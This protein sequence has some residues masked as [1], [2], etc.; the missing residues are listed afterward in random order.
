MELWPHGIVPYVI[1]DEHFDELQIEFIEAIIREINTVSCVKFVVRTTEVNYIQIRFNSLTC[2]SEVGCKGKGR[3]YVFLNN[4]CM[5]RNDI[6][7]E[8]MHVLGFFHEHSRPDRDK[9]IEI[10]WE[11]IFDDNKKNFK[12]VNFYKPNYYHKIY[13]NTTY[14]FTS[15]MHYESRAWSKN[16]KETMIP[17][18]KSVKIKANGLSELDVLKINRLYNCATKMGEKESHNCICAKE[19]KTEVSL[20]LTTE[21]NRGN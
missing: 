12:L 15:V 10:K 16:K 19:L 7:H 5:K 13:E 1:L 14:D 6:L 4:H 20:L 11:N 2:Q 9:Y 8:L 18:N 21:T 3:Q 17:R